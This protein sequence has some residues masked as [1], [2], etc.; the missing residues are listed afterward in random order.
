MSPAK[1][2]G[3]VDEFRLYKQPLSDDSIHGLVW[4][5]NGANN[6]VIPRGIFYDS[7]LYAGLN[8]TFDGNSPFAGAT[9]Y[10]NTNSLP[11]NLN[12]RVIQMVI[13]KNL[14]LAQAWG[15]LDL[16]RT[17]KTNSV[18]AFPYFATVEFYTLGLSW[19]VSKLAANTSVVNGG[20]YSL[21][22]PPA[23]WWQL[24]WNT[25]AGWTERAWN[26]VLAV[27]AF[28]VNV[29]KWLVQ[30]FMSIIKGLTTGN[31]ND[32]QNQVLKPLADALSKFIRFIVDLVKSVL[33]I[34]VSALLA[35]FET[36][37][38]RIAAVYGTLLEGTGRYVVTNQPSEFYVYSREFRKLFEDTLIL[39]SILGL[40]L[41]AIT[42][43]TL[44]FS[45]AAGTVIAVGV[46]LILEQVFA[47][48]SSKS[49]TFAMG[50]GTDLGK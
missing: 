11:T 30:A 49:L 18:T 47:G 1:F 28:F 16:A 48:A 37:K 29:G 33:G 20:N 12:R 45:F 50:G 8:G 14:T 31:W 4:F 27:G 17:N 24:F 32:F 40:A 44:P 5:L 35:P 42:T 46:S 22:P 2:K 34:A 23:N 9:A 26:A 21:P 36:V 38:S 19:E 41:V 6:L 43:L 10:G 13:V 15:I 39:I 25:I 7:K 3:L